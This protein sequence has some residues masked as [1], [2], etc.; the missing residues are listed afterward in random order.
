MAKIL[1]NTTGSPIA[2]DDIGIT[3]PANTNYISH[4]GEHYLLAASLALQ[5][6]VEVGTIIVNDGYDDLK[7]EFGIR[8][9][10]QE[11]LVRPSAFIATSEVVAT[12]NSTSTLTA[13]SRLMVIFTG[14]VAGQVVQL[15]DARTLN[16]G[17][18]YEF[19]NTSTKQI[20]LKDSTSTSLLVLSVAQKTWGVLQ[21]N[22]TQAGVWLFEIGYISGFGGWGGCLNF[23]YQGTAHPDRWLEVVSNNP[24]DETP[25]VI[26]GVRA[27]RAFS[28]SVDTV[29]TGT[30]TLY[31]NGSV[32]DTISLTSSKKNSKLNLNYVLLDQDTL[33]AKV[34][35]GDLS[36][37]NLAV[38]L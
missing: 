28:I 24:T 25:F 1:K 14:T 33:S 36:R 23:G 19:W 37:P 22:S 7:P 26:A 4:P 16:A 15:P 20:S 11:G 13:T 27:V 29:T 35:S 6:A 9:I 5:T 32:L 10:Q 21:D 8:H 18:R 12:A 38:W 2:L 17:H 30:V 31:R 3:I 34:T